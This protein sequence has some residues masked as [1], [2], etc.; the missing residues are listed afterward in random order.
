MDKDK[1]KEQ[2]KLLVDEAGAVAPSISFF[3]QGK[4]YGRVT[5]QNFDYD[6]FIS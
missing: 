2:I 6:A 5:D 1:L 4:K 3:E